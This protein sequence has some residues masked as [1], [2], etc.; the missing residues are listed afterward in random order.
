LLSKLL[1]RFEE[2]NQA[3]WSA[4]RSQ[5]TSWQKKADEINERNFNKARD[6]EQR[7]IDGEVERLKRIRDAV[8]EIVGGNV[9]ISLKHKKIDTAAMIFKDIH[10]TMDYS[11]AADRAIDLAEIFIKRY[12]ERENE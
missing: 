2:I 11:E 8:T 12:K 6:F 4:H 3:N 10:N 5:F 1:K 9:E 7:F